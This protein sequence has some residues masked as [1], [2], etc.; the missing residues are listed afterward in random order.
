M[1]SAGYNNTIS[2][3]QGFTFFHSPRLPFS[4]A[5][6][7]RR[8]RLARRDL[9][10]RA[11]TK[12]GRLDEGTALREIDRTVKTIGKSHGKFYYHTVK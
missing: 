2:A 1:S 7:A 11:P 6:R 12:S 3:R 9:R 8:R 5:A 4:Q 10:A